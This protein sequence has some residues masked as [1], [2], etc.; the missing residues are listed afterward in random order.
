MD[1]PVTCQCGKSQRVSSAAAGTT[2]ICGCG[3]GITVPSLRALRE[4]AAITGSQPK[5]YLERILADGKYP[6]KAECVCC[7]EPT[8]DLQY[9]RVQADQSG[10]LEEK[11][12]STRLTY[13][14]AI[15]GWLLFGWLGGALLASAH[16]KRLKEL[17]A[18][19]KEVDLDLPLFVCP[20]CTGR[21]KRVRGIKAALRSIPAYQ[22]L[23][24]A[25]PN[26][27]VRR[28]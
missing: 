12:R 2:V 10:I 11:Q 18:I 28:L 22:D 19:P 21:V 5:L 3:M 9:F 27:V 4:E 16:S 13:A 14:A 26:L 1:F 25:Y 17:A 8:Q 24:D 7:G 23:F 6:G 20:G 15:I